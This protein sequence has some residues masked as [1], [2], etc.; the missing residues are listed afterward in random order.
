MKK[1]INIIIIALLLSVTGCYDL[2]RA[3]FNELSSSTFWKTEA[4]CKQGLMAVYASLKKDDLYG[5]QFLTDVNSDI[6]D[7]YD[8]YEVLQL[9]TMTNRTGFVL[10]KWQ[11]GYNGIQ[12]ANLAIHNIE[13]ADID[14]TVK[15]QMIGEAKFL[16]ALIYFHL[17]DYFGRLPLYDETVDLEKDI[18][19]LKKARSSDTE[20]LDFI[21]NDLRAALN[22][23]LPVNYP[24]SDYGR[25]TQGSVYALL[26]KVY[27]YA[28]NYK[29]SIKAFEEVVKSE[30]GYELN[31][32]F[33]DLFCPQ[34]NGNK[35]MVF[36]IVNTG[37][38][39]K[40]NGMPFAWYAGT[41]TTFGSCWNNTVPST[42]LADM[43]EYID[44]RP[45]NWD[46]LFPGYTTDNKV[47][48]KVMCTIVS[49]DGTAV[50]AYPTERE[51]VLAMYDQ[52]DPRF[53][54]TLIAPY[55]TYES[56]PYPPYVTLIYGRKVSDGEIVATNGVNGFMQNNRGTSWESYFWRKFVPEGDWNKAI[57]DRAHTPVNYCIIR[58]ADVYLMLAE[59][60]NE[61]GQQAKAVEYINKVRGRAGIAFLNSGPAWL[62]ANTKD[63]VFNRIFREKAF[64]FANEGIRDSDLRR[65]R[66]SDKLLN[67][68]DYGVTGRPMLTRIFEAKR[69]YLWPVP[70]A[71]RDYNP[72]LEQNPGW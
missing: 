49:D 36:G 54:A 38:V 43:Y 53:S 22:A 3:P 58:L 60:Y 57:N 56:F 14:E 13:S 34:G 21:L 61:D 72:E 10:G 62:T 18:N 5:K 7:G 23:G 46:E 4:Q 65:W 31:V 41:R 59:A 12:S 67:R 47:K 30:Y 51:Q 35:E 20:T 69:D 68:V 32:S 29:E 2:D 1:Y 6:A 11:N 71:E 66:L 40:D 39:G 15:K 44:G 70:G 50:V 45:F 37:G 17:Y 9:G 25:V 64:E 48:E 52:R 19:N 8:Q 27:L 26:G 16:R 63:E 33:A 28:K 55:S 42:N 24:A